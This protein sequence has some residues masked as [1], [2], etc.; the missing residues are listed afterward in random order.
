MGHSNALS[1]K[2]IDFFIYTAILLIIPHQKKALHFSNGFAALSQW[3]FPPGCHSVL[4]ERG[5]ILHDV[6]AGNLF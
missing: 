4:C 5:W 1:K 2:K 6:L 3:K